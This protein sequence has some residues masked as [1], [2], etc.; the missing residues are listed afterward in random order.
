MRSRCLFLS[1]SSAVLASLGLWAPLLR[2]QDALVATV[3]VEAST[4]D[5]TPAEEDFLHRHT[6]Q[7]NTWELGAFAGLLFISDQNSFRG[8][9][10]VT[11][12][13]VTLRP[14]SQYEQPA[15]EL[16]A[17]LAYFPLA[18][19]GAEVEG[20]VGLATADEGNSGTLWAART[21]VV[22]QA[23]FWRVVPFAVGG[24]GYWAV[25]NKASGNDSD[26]AFHFGGGVKLAANENV[27]FRID[28]R[29]TI[30][31]QRAY[32]DVPNSLEVAAGASLQLG[33]A[34]P[35]PPDADGDGFL[36]GQDTCP[37][38]PGVAPDGCPT[39]DRDGDQIMDDGDR[40]PD[41]PGL[42]PT[43]CP[44]IDA[45]G[46]GIPDSDDQCLNEPGL[47]PIGCPDGDADG[48]LDRDDQC[49][50]VAGVL[51][52]GCPG[53]T[54]QDGFADP[55][56]KCPTEAESKNGFEDDDGCPDALPEAVKKFTG[57]IAGIQFDLNKA[58]IRASSFGTLQQ[59]AKLLQ[60]YPSLRVEI[61]GHTD[62]T[63]SREH[64]LG[65]S[66]ERADSVK[67]YLV[68]QGVPADRI[69]TRGAGPDEPLVPEK[70]SAARQ[71]NRRI[72]FRIVQ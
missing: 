21:H 17:R 63:G 8:P 26:P 62:D 13:E 30:T 52:R 40:C 53:D 72:E 43:G 55:D 3:A 57:V 45:D 12:G 54:D 24:A 34:K 22:V 44:A 68:A 23:P 18:F 56:D 71:K 5:T 7:A 66:H 31:N 9:G 38:E 10:S 4:L 65:L 1:G 28:V 50:G 20:M 70:N 59:A 32:G 51:P 58:S 35:L 69:S 48:I 6:P 33:R 39:R 47:A 14:Y 11:N 64:N 37:S 16:G 27:S 25:L 41:Q 36:N 61:A 60:E 2:A 46:D 29:D 15:P 67:S 49:P 42:A 19:L